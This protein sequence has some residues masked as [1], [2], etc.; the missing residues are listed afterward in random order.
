MKLQGISLAELV[1]HERSAG[2]SWPKIAREVERRTEVEIS[3]ETLRL[4][5]KETESL[6][7]SA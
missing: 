1:N 4:W 5:F 6:A 2:R 7:A 3:H